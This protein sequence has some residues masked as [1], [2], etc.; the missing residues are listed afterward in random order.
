MAKYIFLINHN[1][2]DSKEIVSSINKKQP[3]RCGE[4]EIRVWLLGQLYQTEK[5]GKNATKL[6]KLVEMELTGR[7]VFYLR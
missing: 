3:R 4:F 1:I 7:G 6:G 5:N 2:T